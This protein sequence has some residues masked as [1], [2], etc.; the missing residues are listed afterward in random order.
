MPGLA[1]QDSVTYS[2]MWDELWR[3]SLSRQIT[4]FS[5]LFIAFVVSLISLRKRIRL[6]RWGN[7]TDWRNAHLI[8]GLLITVTLLIHTGAR[9]GENLDALLMICFTVALISG[10]LLA[11]SIANEH[12]LSPTLARRVRISSLWL[13]L[14]ALWPLPALLIFHVLKS[15]Y[16]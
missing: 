9:P 7:Y 2:I 3:N 16:F 1:Y 14:L 11:S 8:L 10:G 4:G 6:F 15:Y 13:H 12:K 5:L